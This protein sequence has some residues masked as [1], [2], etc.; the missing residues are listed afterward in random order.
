MT[1]R[2]ALPLAA[3]ALLLAAPRVSAQAPPLLGQPAP[4]FRLAD[5]EGRTLSLGDLR[6]RLVVLHFGA[7]W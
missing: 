7:S 3:A 2:R 6:G 5:L 4:P 1:A